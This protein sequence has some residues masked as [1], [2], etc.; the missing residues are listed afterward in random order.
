MLTPQ[1]RIPLLLLALQLA[2]SLP[3]I[4][5]PHA[6]PS[7]SKATQRVADIHG[8]AGPWAVVGY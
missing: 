3:A 5:H 2:V 8:G 4:A 1:Q 6:A 7:G